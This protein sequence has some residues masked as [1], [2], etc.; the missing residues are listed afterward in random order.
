M[1]INVNEKL[2]INSE[3]QQW[4]I[5]KLSG[6]LKTGEPKWVSI[7]YYSNLQDAA[8]RLFTMQV[9]DINSSDIQEI[10]NKMDSI[11][12]EIKSAVRPFDE[13]DIA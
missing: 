8:Q 4:Q 2:R 5:H 6:K 10:L 3:N 12:R 9:M 1:I 13:L 11:G 7:Y